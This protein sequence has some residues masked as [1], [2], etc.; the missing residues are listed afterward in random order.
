MNVEDLLLEQYKILEKR[1]NY[2]GRIFW[3]LPTFS[4]G[5]FALV[6]SLISRE[7]AGLLI[8]FCISGL[9]FFFVAW[10]ARRLQENQDECELKLVEL[11]DKFRKDISLQLISL[12]VSRKYGARFRTYVFLMLC[13]VLSWALALYIFIKGRSSVGGSDAFPGFW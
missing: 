10:M 7:G 11:E 2:L 1:R 3:Q 6:I 13:G 8:P 12:P 4:V 5:I 9:L